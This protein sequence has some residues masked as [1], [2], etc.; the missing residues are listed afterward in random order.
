MAKV[1]KL[2][3]DTIMF[4]MTYGYNLHADTETRAKLENI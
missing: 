4:L 2:D 3:K 1:K